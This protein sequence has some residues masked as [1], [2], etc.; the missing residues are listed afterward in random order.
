MLRWTAG[1]L[2]PLSGL[3]GSSRTG[4]SAPRGR[5]PALRERSDSKGRPRPTSPPK[6]KRRPFPDGVSIQGNQILAV[7]ATAAVRAS[8]TAMAA[9]AVRTTPTAMR[10]ARTVG[11]R[12]VVSVGASR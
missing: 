1:R 9:R 2:S 7:S 8:S 6:I 10:S 3:G 4:M 12:G 11:R 5:E